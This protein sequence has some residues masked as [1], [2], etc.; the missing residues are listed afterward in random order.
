MSDEIP[1]KIG[2]Y[3]VQRLLG[4]GAMGSVFLGRDPELDRAVS[5][6]FV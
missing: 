2:R 5:Y 1:E 3:D 4:R 6:N